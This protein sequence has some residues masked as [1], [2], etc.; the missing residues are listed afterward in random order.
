M[1]RYSDEFKEQMM[2][3]LMPPSS[4]SVA[5]LARETGISAPTLYAWKRQFQKWGYIVPSTSSKPHGWDSKAKLAAVINTAALNEAE[6]SAWCREHGV[7]PEQLDA[8]KRSFEAHD[9]PA[10]AADL[11]SERRRRRRAEKELKRKE[12]ALAETAAL[13]TLSKKAEAIWG[14]DGDE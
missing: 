12:R 1:S 7:Y 8:W 6:R 3:K 5:G 13:L 14:I 10:S 11:A 9:S 4:Q 2:R